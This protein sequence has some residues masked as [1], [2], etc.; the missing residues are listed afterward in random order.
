MSKNRKPEKRVESDVLSM[1]YALGMSLDVI[2]SKAV[3][4]VRA[5]R[6][7][8]GSA[9]E[10]FPDLVGNDKNG[11]AC[12]IELKSPANKNGLSDEQRDFLMKKIEFCVFAACTYSADHFRNL[13]ENWAALD[14][15]EAQEFLRASLPK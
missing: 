8:R 15:K 3:Y 13:Y 5:K 12:Y 7:L 10:G 2:E 14:G 4:S 6:Y 9:P 1:A 11:T